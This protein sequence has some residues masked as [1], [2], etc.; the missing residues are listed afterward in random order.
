[1]L[2]SVRVCPEVGDLHPNCFHNVEMI[3]AIS[4]MICYK[5]GKGRKVEKKMEQLEK[6]IEKVSMT[7]SETRK[8]NYDFPKYFLSKTKDKTGWWLTYPSETY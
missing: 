1:M 2:E 3:A 7:Q 4:A 5:L 6:S 8:S